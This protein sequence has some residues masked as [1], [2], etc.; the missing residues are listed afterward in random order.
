MKAETYTNQRMRICLWIV[1]LLT[2][3]KALT[4]ANINDYW[5]SDTD[6]SDGKPMQR[7]T[8]YNYVG[9]IYSLLHVVIECDRRDG[10]RYKITDRDNDD[11]AAQW[12]MQ[13]FAATEAIAGSS[14]LRD[15]ILLETIPSG[16]EYLSLI[17]E[18]MRTNCK[19]T[20]VYQQFSEGSSHTVTEAEPYCIK[21]YHQR[22]YVLV[23]EYRTLLVSHEK[24]AEMHI[25]ALDRI[26]SLNITDH[27][28]RLDPDFDAQQYFRYAFGTRVEKDNPP[29]KV[30]LRVTA[31]QAPYLRTLPLHHSQREVET[32]DEYSIFELEVALTVELYM[33]I[34]Y[35]GSNIEVLAPTE[36]HD[37]IH[38]QIVDMADLYGIIEPPTE[39][40]L[41]AFLEEVKKHPEEYDKKYSQD[42]YRGIF[43]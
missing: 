17:T 7:R 2:R 22:W 15:R 42:I 24:V 9:A 29:C 30:V 37:I 43:R 41:D 40:D 8:F 27:T 23:K 4:L 16:Q 3:H 31:Q 28:F 18:A 6:I 11:Q 26:L 32:T 12:L 20:F 25:Y 13:S 36:L 21:L 1:N 5:T 38:N 10:F 35:Y 19:I 34:L 33:Q 39:E 14:D